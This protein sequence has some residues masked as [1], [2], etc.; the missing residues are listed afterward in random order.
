[1]YAKVKLHKLARVGWKGLKQVN[2]YTAVVLPPA[3]AGGIALLAVYYGVE[4]E[5]GRKLPTEWSSYTPKSLTSG[6]LMTFMLVGT[7][8][9]TYQQTRKHP[10]LANGST[11][12]GI[13]T[14]GTLSGAMQQCNWFGGIAVGLT[15]AGTIIIVA[16]VLKALM[17]GSIKRNMAILRQVKEPQQGTEGIVSAMQIGMAIY[18]GIVVLIALLH[19]DVSSSARPLL[20]VFAGVG[21]MAA[22]TVSSEHTLKNYM[23]IAGMIVSLVGSYIQIDLAIAA[24]DESGASASD[25]MF[26]AV[27]LAFAPFTVFASQKHQLVRTLTVPVLAAVIVF[28]IAISITMIPAIVTSQGCNVSDNLFALVLPVI[29]ITATVFGVAAFFIVLWALTLGKKAPPTQLNDDA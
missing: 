16:T 4:W 25:I 23:A 19:E 5:G 2:V 7:A 8:F 1:M 24:A 21:M 14:T 29:S 28:L 22:A 12:T 20:L 17:N 6:L 9:V 3:V 26:V 18:M 27:I 11:A 15:A 10:T 13:A